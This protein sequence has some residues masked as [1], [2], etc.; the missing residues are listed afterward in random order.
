MHVTI[1]E[2]FYFLQAEISLCRV[3]KRA[4]VEDHPSL[5]RTLPTTR[6]TSSRPSCNNPD[7]RQQYSQNLLNFHSSE[8]QNSNQND[9]KLS[10]TS[11]SSTTDI[12][13][14][15]LG[16]SSPIN[17]HCYNNFI[18]SFPPISTTLPPHTSSLV[19]SPSVFPNN[20]DDLNR[21]L[22]YQQA[23]V[24]NPASQSFHHIQNYQHKA[25]SNFIL[26]PQLQLQ[27]Q[28]QSQHQQALLALNN[29][30][31]EVQV[32]FPERLWEWNS[33]PS[34]VN[35]DYINPFK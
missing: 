26:Q 13:G 33:M 15:A 2:F 16:L 29:L 22:S 20:V 11:G 1:M 27:P 32:A 3:Y 35:K 31:G 4:G 25:S 12:V 9:D 8:S 7:K 24:N 10:E 14:T 23:S 21:I 17:Q 18:T 28:P 19:P 6:A 34:D 5:P 30:A